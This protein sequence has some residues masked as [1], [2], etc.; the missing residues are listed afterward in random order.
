[1]PILQQCKKYL[2][3]MWRGHLE[4]YKLIGVLFVELQ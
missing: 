4:C 2:G 1:M 3:R